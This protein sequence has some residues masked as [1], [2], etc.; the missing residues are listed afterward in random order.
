M[1]SNLHTRLRANASPDGG[2]EILGAI[3]D[4][5]QLQDVALSC[6]FAEMLRVH[7]ALDPM[8]LCPSAAGAQL[9]AEPIT[10]AELTAAE[11]L[12]A[13]ARAAR[14]AD[15]D[16]ECVRRLAERAAM[17]ASRFESYLMER[18]VPDPVV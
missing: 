3:V 1:T 16:D 14:V 12:M 2:T 13:V 8:D 7:A 17:F 4:D 5:L 6:E 15:L 18:S 10:P 11:V 9:L